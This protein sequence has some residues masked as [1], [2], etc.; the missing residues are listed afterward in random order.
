MK[1]TLYLCLIAGSLWLLLA[2]LAGAQSLGDFARQ[3]RQT[4]RPSTAK[5]Y[6]NDDIPSLAAPKPEAAATGQPSAGKDAKT[7][8]KPPAEDKAKA[9]AALQAKAD[10]LNKQIAL[11]EREYTVAEREYKL[12]TAV[13]YADAGN[14]LR[15]PKKWA[16]QDRQYQAEMAT[17]KKA[18]DDA[19]QKLADLQ[20]Q[21]RKEGLRVQ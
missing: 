7:E 14:S 6:T 13:Y 19:R 4:K 8:A 11:L 15:D 16:E 12:R 18:I 9:A 3:Q 2:G 21:A 17:K 10:A 20:E 5:V 1:R